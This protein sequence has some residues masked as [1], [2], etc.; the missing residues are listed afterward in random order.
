MKKKLSVLVILVSITLFVFGLIFLA[1]RYAFYKQ[2]E[3][4]E[5]VIVKIDLVSIAGFKRYETFPLSMDVTFSFLD[6]TQRTT[7][8]TLQVSTPSLITGMLRTGSIVKLLYKPK[9]EK[10]LIMDELVKNIGPTP[11]EVR[12]YTWHYW[13]YPIVVMLLGPILYLVFRSYKKL[14]ENKN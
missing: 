11:Y 6:S 10:Q 9:F 7:L 14:K 13:F 2:S 1:D 4:T 12:I 8:S 5:G 3:K